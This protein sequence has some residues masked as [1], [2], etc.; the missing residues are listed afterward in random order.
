MLKRHK[1]H[2]RHAKPH[3]QQQHCTMSCTLS[4]FIVVLLLFAATTAVVLLLLLSASI[5]WFDNNNS[6]DKLWCYNCSVTLML[7][8]V[9][10][11]L[12][13]NLL[14]LLVSFNSIASNDGRQCWYYNS[15]KPS[16]RVNRT[17][18]TSCENFATYHNFFPSTTFRFSALHLLVGYLVGLFV[19]L[20]ESV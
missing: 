2:S 9:E 17:L 5:A 20:F 8:Y 18:I 11:V 13:P 19:Y 3:I 10:S 1:K 15:N 6:N 16:E 7:P 14:A 12:Y 4:L